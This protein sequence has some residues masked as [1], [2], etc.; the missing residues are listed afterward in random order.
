MKQWEDR[1]STPPVSLLSNR[2]NTLQC[3]VCAHIHM[4]H[5]RVYMLVCAHMCIYTH[6]CAHVYTCAYMCAHVLVYKELP[7]NRSTL[8]INF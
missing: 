6:A 2:R 1:R 8:T 7:H 5:T 3:C 4:F